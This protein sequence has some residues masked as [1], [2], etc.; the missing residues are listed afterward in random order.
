MALMIV[1]RGSGSTVFPTRKI[2]EAPSPPPSSSEEISRMSCRAQ[3]LDSILFIYDHQDIY[4][5]IYIL[6]Y[7]LHVYIYI[8]LQT[9][10]LQTALHAVLDTHIYYMSRHELKHAC[11][12]AF[13]TYMKLDRSFLLPSTSMVLGSTESAKMEGVPISTC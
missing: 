12:N 7:E 6:Y 11:M 9:A 1:A 2:G 5:Y 10:L 3:G 13:E 4:I 8:H